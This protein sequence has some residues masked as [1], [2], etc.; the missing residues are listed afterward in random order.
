MYK[1][2]VVRGYKTR[3]KTTND[4]RAR[5]FVSDEN[6][7]IG[8]TATPVWCGKMDH[9][10]DDRT[11]I[12][13]VSGERWCCCRDSCAHFTKPDNRTPFAEPPCIDIGG[14]G[15]KIFTPFRRRMRTTK[16]VFSAHSNCWS[17]KSDASTT[18]AP[19]DTRTHT[20]A[21]PAT[22]NDS[23][24]RWGNKEVRVDFGHKGYGAA[25]RRC[26]PCGV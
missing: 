19:A 21:R 16:S 23:R 3:I 15:T 4:L 10:N 7:T 5:R 11:D 12:G 25:N 26:W 8:S 9:N 14:P 6:D 20:T 17:E 18:D 24:P 13:A 2:N 1:Y 22:G